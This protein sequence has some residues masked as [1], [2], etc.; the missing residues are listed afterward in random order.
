MSGERTSAAP[1]PVRSATPILQGMQRWIIHTGGGEIVPVD[2]PMPD[3]ALVGG[4]VHSVRRNGHVS[5]KVRLLP[6]GS[7]I[8]RKNYFGQQRTCAAPQVTYVNAG[9]G[10]A[11]VKANA[12]D[13]TAG[14]RLERNSQLERRV[15]SIINGRRDPCARP[16]GLLAGR[17]RGAGQ[18]SGEAQEPCS[19]ISKE[20]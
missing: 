16:N 7:G 10:C 5:R 2:A 15:G 13:G 17:V 8:P 3:S 6:A 9:V 11:L 18:Y 4:H 20:L 12:S 1:Y 14:V 19:R